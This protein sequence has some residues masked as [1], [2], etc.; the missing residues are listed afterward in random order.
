MSERASTISPRAC[1]GDMYCGVPWMT[2]ITV[3]LDEMVGEVCSTLAIPKS[4][5]F[6]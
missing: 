4:I 1:S 6:T 5:T 2:P 3:A